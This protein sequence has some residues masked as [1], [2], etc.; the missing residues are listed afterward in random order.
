MPSSIKAAAAVQTKM[1][2][3]IHTERAV[4]E[5]ETLLRTAAGAEKMPEPTSRLIMIARPLT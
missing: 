4:V 1:P 2:V 5:V 3:R